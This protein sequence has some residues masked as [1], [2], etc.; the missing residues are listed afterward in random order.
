MSKKHATK[1]SPEVQ[2]PAVCVLME[3]GAERAPR[4]IV[5]IEAIRVFGACAAQ[6][7]GAG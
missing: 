1:Y 2:D 6:L 5:A 4:A 7:G 3:R